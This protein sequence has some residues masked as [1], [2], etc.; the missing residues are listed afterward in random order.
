VQVGA[1]KP[2]RKESA[3]DL[4]RKK[5]KPEHPQEIIGD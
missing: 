1:R 3:E 2:E 4:R 5:L